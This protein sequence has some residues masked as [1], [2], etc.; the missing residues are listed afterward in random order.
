MDKINEYIDLTW[1]I[2]N[3]NKFPLGKD[4]LEPLENNEKYADHL[5]KCF[6]GIN[7]LL[8]DSGTG[9]EDFALKS[10][11]NLKLRSKD[12]RPA[13]ELSDRI[14]KLEPNEKEF[15]KIVVLYHD[16]GKAIH[17]DKHAMLGKHL[18]KTEK[19]THK[20]FN[21]QFK[22][23]K[24]DHTYFYF[25]LQIVG[26][27]D[28]MGTLCTGESSPLAITDACGLAYRSTDEAQRLLN[29]ITI[30]NLA[31]IYG[32]ITLTKERFKMIINDWY[33]LTSR[34][35]NSN[36]NVSPQ[37]VLDNIVKHSKS[38]NQF[39]ERICRLAKCCIHE[40][41]IKKNEKL[42]TED[43]IHKYKYNIMN[44]LSSNLVHSVASQ[45]L[46]TRLPSISKDA[47]F[48]CKLDYFKR[49]LK[50]I[51]NE[52]FDHIYNNKLHSDT[53]GE[54]PYGNLENLIRCILQI[55][56]ELI[57]SYRSLLYE[58]NKEATKHIGVELLS[59]T[60]QNNSMKD[61]SEVGSQI[62]KLLL[63]DDHSKGLDWLKDEASVFFFH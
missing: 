58:D 15:L 30:V 16:I 34:L 39:I 8:S 25:L 23:F 47:A 36:N 12:E 57:V 20:N 4:Y 18:I 28:L 50:I 42:K 49:L 17:N 5:K 13:K 62:A 55:V 46:G 53:E 31:D 7:L 21:D 3:Y 33:E 19:S 1:P 14:K 40:A 41:E 29:Y 32:S 56:S 10:K 27:H 11:I 26:H 38:Q 6:E 60:R 52:W 54:I 43:A 63:F 59:I 35:E 9:L 61:V 48:F 44:K 22:S 37:D 51:T 45:V 2:N 24:D